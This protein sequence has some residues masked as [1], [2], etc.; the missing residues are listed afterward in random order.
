MKFNHIS[1]LWFYS[2]FL[3]ELNFFFKSREKLGMNKM[4]TGSRPNPHALKSMTR[5]RPGKYGP[6]LWLKDQ[7]Y[8]NMTHIPRPYF[9]YLGFVIDFRESVLGLEFD[10]NLFWSRLWLGLEWAGLDYNTVLTT[11]KAENKFDFFCV[12]FPN[13]WHWS[14]DSLYEPL[15]IFCH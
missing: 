9:Y 1:V 7:D 14:C 5:P 8:N 15:A 13:L 4:L 12:L 11:K 3:I 10:S 2:C 6:G